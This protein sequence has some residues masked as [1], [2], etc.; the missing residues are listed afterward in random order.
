MKFNGLLVGGE[1]VL[2]LEDHSFAT[3]IMKIRSDKIH[4]WMLY[5]EKILMRMFAS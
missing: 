2:D 4:Q 3:M 1:V 5:L